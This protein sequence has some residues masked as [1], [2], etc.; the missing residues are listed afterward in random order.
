MFTR[1]KKELLKV[2]LLSYPK[3]DAPTSLMV[4][5]SDTAV[6]AVLQQFVDEHWRP[7]AFFSKT[8]SQTE[9]RYSTFGRELLGIY[10]AIKHF[11]HFLE[12]R[13]F[14]IF[15]DHKPLTYAL[16][17]STTSYTAREIRQMAYILEF[18]HDIRFVRGQQNTVADALSRIAINTYTPE[19]HSIDFTA[20]AMAQKNDAE[21]RQLQESSSLVLEE[22]S[23]PYCPQPLICDVSGPAPRL[24]LTPAF[25]R[26]AFDALHTLS[27]PGIKATQRLISTRYVWP[28]MN[29]DVR[30]WARTCL[31]CQRSKIGRHT[32]TPLAAFTPP[33]DR[34]DH[35]HLDLVGP[36][37]SSGS[38]RYIFTCIDRFTRWPEVMP[39]PDIT[40][41]TVTQAFLSTWVSRYGVPSTVTTDQGRQFSRLSSTTYQNS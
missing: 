34:F 7:V 9:T 1:I 32:V 36:L 26:V 35:V 6:G 24:Y 39:I 31:S 27:H 15:T 38:F 37:P 17:S 8:L 14:F 4:D 12:G 11:H 13:D 21:L 20:L 19:R 18:T 40:A 25:R 16:T 5:A 30:R 23:L 29:A 28:K 2:T 10:L 41:E 33:D 22:V 3:C